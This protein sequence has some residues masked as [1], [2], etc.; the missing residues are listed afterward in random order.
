[1]RRNDLKRRIRAKLSALLLG[2]A[3][4][5][6]PAASEVL[7]RPEQ[8]MTPEERV[9]FQEMAAETLDS[10]AT[11][12]TIGTLDKALAKLTS[13]TKFR[14][15]IQFARAMAMHQDEK[16]STAAALEAADESIRLLP[17][18]SGPLLLAS[19]LYTYS[20][21][22]GIAADY[23]L[24]ASRIDPQIAA[25]VPDHQIESLFRRLSFKQD[26]RRVRLLSDRLLEIG[27]LA[28][29]LALRSS[30]VRRA[31]EA[32]LVEDDVAGARALVP[33]L[34]SPDDSFSLLAQKR[35]QPLWPAIEQWAGP[36]LE[37]QWRS[38]LAEL[39]AKWE[40]SGNLADARPY[41][42]ALDSA[43]HDETIIR[44]ILPLYSKPLDK[45]AD[46]ELLYLATT[47][48]GALARKG[49]WNDIEAMY[50][51]ASKVWD[52]AEDMNALNLDAN[53][54][55][56]LLYAGKPTESLAVVD[57]ALKQAERWRS[58][59]SDALLSMH[60]HRACT[61]HELKRDD[62]ALLSRGR[63]AARLSPVSVAGLNLCLGR[64][65]LARQVL[66]AGLENEATRAQVIAFVQRRDDFGFQ[67][68]YGRRMHAQIAALRADAALHAAV[69]KYGRVLPFPLSAGAPPELAAAQPL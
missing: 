56:Y 28:E 47:V 67:S 55:R 38:Y 31:I 40:A 35:Y 20:D 11:G 8:I 26:Q 3:L 29:S 33:R 34:V 42:E 62:E 48:A 23:L 45:V 13:P 16:E 15:F 65:D 1:M 6:T 19:Q 12:P 68:E 17:E 69:A 25:Q 21:R 50:A 41:V 44:T 59:N 36:M 66:I 2:V 27:W 51:R 37:R 49:R 43:D 14:G 7:P 9:L 10:G 4:S 5:A 54:A 63:A 46:Y 53:R 39:R 57:A 30:L 52:P 58:I 64:P 60:L 18:Y 22:P 61:L 32:R 24:R